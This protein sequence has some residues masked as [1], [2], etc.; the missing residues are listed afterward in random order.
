MAI[1]TDDGLYPATVYRAE[2]L[3]PQEIASTLAALAAR[4]GSGALT[5]EDISGGTFTVSN[6]GTKWCGDSMLLIL[7]SE[8]E[9]VSEDDAFVDAVRVELLERGETRT[10]KWTKTLRRR[11]PWQGRHFLAV[12]DSEKRHEEAD[13]ENN[14]LVSEELPVPDP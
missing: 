5:R 9:F 11:T 2:S 4:A 1:A 3:S 12:L 14:N 10:F 13:E 8:D 7:L 6:L